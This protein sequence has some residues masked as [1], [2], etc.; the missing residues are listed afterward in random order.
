VAL[1]PGGRP[2]EEFLI[3]P[4]QPAER[5]ALGLGSV[6]VS[7]ID[8]DG[9]THVFDIVGREHYPTV[10]GFVDE[11]RRLGV[12]RRVARTIDFSRLT[13][14]SRLVLLHEHAQIAN[15]LEFPSDARCPCEV[16]EHLEES[17]RGM[18][19][20][21]W[22]QEPLPAAAH[23]LGI[24]AVF[25]IPQIEVVRDPAGGTHVETIDRA[26]NASMPVVEVDQ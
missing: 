13:G 26:S 9:V 24:F 12:S 16:D 17:F 14:D 11:A 6:G 5:E 8:V 7:L 2:V 23:R 18:C 4:P 21:L 22:W 10:A 1:G 15:A 19:A 3:D 25:P 20:R